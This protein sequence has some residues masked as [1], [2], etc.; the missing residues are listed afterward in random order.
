M[1]NIRTRMSIRSERLGRSNHEI[2][3]V[4]LLMEDDGFESTLNYNIP[5][6]Q[7]PED[8]IRDNN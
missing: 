3:Y 6:Y 5:S 1:K 2:G 4:I 8:L 7:Q